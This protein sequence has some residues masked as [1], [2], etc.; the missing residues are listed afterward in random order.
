MT[1]QR[2]LD[3]LDDLKGKEIIVTGGTSGIGLCI[4]K[5]LLYKGA[6]VVIMAR[7]Q[8]K[9]KDVIN[10]LLKKYQDRKVSFIQYDQSSNE[11]ILVAAKEIKE[12]H[13]NF[14]ALIL[15]AGIFQTK[16]YLSYVDGVPLTIKT[17]CVGL[18]FLLDNL[19]SELSG[20]HRFIF[21]GSVVAS[22]NIKKVNSLKSDSISCWQQYLISKAGVESIFY[23]Y[24]KTLNEHYHFY[25]VEPGL[26]NSEIIRDFPTPIKQMG[27]I[28]LKIFSHS[29][30]KAALTAMKALQENIKENSFIIPRGLFTFMGY[31]KIIKFSKKRQRDYLY[32][33]IKKT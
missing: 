18:S 27:H 29:T 23:H 6:D 5:Q 20:N 17:N 28:F 19:L 3:S 16:K 21:Q 9:A 22:W 33:L 24:S 13:P 8:N 32:D 25:L 10:N 26:T 31:P 11:S 7:N 12:Q 2:Y 1:V 30:N 15:N 4:V 14:Y